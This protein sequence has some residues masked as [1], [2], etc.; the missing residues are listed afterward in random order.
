V[1]EPPLFSPD[2]FDAES[3][4][5]NV[6]AERKRRFD[7]LAAEDPRRVHGW[8]VILEP[9]YSAPPLWKQ[10]HFRGKSPIGPEEL[11]ASA[12]LSARVWEWSNEYTHGGGR[13]AT[14]EAWVEEGRT[15]AGL[16][17]NELQM[18]VEYRREVLVPET[19]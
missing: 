17:S 8:W 16:L 14:A 3:F 7:A 13:W 4:V 19:H 2:D 9:E 11:G 1:A 15:I 10:G 5:R 18:P 6:I 12:S